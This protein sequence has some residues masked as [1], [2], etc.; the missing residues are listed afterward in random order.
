MRGWGWFILSSASP[1]R[2]P[3]PTARRS[4]NRRARSTGYHNLFL[5]YLSNKQP[6]EALKVLDEAARQPKPDA[7]FLTGL[8]ELYV[9]LGRRRR[10]K[11]TRR[12]KQSAR[13]VEPGRRN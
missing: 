12:Q 11:K 4:E 13:A 10:R 3:P 5:A 6:Q 7:D 9:N 2:R 1:I 8:A